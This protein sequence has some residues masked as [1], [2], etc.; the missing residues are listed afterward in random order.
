MNFRNIKTKKPSNRN[1]VIY[2]QFNTSNHNIVFKMQWEYQQMSIQDIYGFLL[3]AIK[4]L[5]S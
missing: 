5:D 1:Q 2:P 4:I 3:E